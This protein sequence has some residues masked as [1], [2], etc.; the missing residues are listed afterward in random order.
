MAQIALFHSVLG[1]RQGVRD[2]ERVLRSR[3]HDVLIV[4][5]YAGKVF[6]NY[7][8]ASEYAESVGFPAL[9]RAAAGPLMKLLSDTGG[10]TRARLRASRIWEISGGSV[11]V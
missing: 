5:L 7:V 10:A 11:S 6:D 8:E 3:G 2:L 1:V 4:D 9:M